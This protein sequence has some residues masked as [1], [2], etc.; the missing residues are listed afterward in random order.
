MTKRILICEDTEQVVSVL[1]SSLERLAGGKA[2]E[3]TFDVMITQAGTKQLSAQLAGDDYDLVLLDYFAP[4]G[5]FHVL[6]FEKIGVEKV[7]AISS[8]PGY[9][10]RAL[11]RGALYA[12]T[13]NNP[14]T[15]VVVTDIAEKAEHILYDTTTKLRQRSHNFDNTAS[16]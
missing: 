15:E 4:D 14:L 2:D 13:K 10:Q 9:N 7:I 3:F 11:E 5:N 1:R 8:I 12:I 16:S 6:E